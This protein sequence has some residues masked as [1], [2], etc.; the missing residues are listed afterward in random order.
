MAA[1]SRATVESEAGGSRVYACRKLHRKTVAVGA[2]REVVVIGT[3]G[4]IGPA[5]LFLEWYGSGKPVPA[6][7]ADEASDFDALVMTPRGVFRWDRFCRPERVLERFAAIGSGSKA[8][9]GAMWAGAT[10][11]QAVR[12]AAKVDP[13]TDGRVVSMRLRNK[14]A[15]PRV[16]RATRGR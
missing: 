16:K 5:A 7:F 14:A 3:A 8:A 2:R 12:Y 10:A 13:Y 11:A 4:E 9:L 6:A 15:R 1:D